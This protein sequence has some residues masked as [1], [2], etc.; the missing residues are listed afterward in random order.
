MKLQLKKST[1]SILRI[2]SGLA[3]LTFALLSI[4]NNRSLYLRLIMQFCVLSMILFLGLVD[5]YNLKKRALG[6]FLLGVS[7]L[8]LI[9]MIFT[10]G[11][12]LRNGEF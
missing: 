8:I 1:I 7:I 3:T 5:I 9:S 10:Y 12:A 4:L 2:I 6:Y 11:V